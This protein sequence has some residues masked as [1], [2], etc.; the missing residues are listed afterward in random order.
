MKKR[1][2][3]VA[4]IAIRF[5]TIRGDLPT[6]ACIVGL[7]SFQRN[8]NNVDFGR[9]ELT[10]HVSRN[11]DRIA[12]DSQ[13]N[14]FLRQSAMVV[15]GYFGLK[16][17]RRNNSSARWNDWIACQLCKRGC[18]NNTACRLSRIVRSNS[19]RFKLFPPPS[20]VSCLHSVCVYGSH[21]HFSLPSSL[22]RVVLLPVDSILGSLT[23]NR[24][25]LDHSFIHCH[26]SELKNSGRFLYIHKKNLFC[27]QHFN[28]H[29][30]PTSFFHTFC[31]SCK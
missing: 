21:E 26:L 22:H 9:F 31:H 5:N 20:S 4:Q 28:R 23:N 11:T 25:R 24:L 14:K 30:L 19:G 6:T 29:I 1:R 18:K 3:I 2:Q 8:K 27:A 12:D 10:F 7:F 13:S 15:L 16:P 17:Q